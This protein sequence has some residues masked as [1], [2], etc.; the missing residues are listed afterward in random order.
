L[1]YVSSTDPNIDGAL[2]WGIAFNIPHVH[3]LIGVSL[4]IGGSDK[5]K[6]MSWGGKLNLGIF[7]IEY[8]EVKNGFKDFFIGGTIIF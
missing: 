8:A 1:N 5:E 2:R 3:Q 6:F 4:H 7:H